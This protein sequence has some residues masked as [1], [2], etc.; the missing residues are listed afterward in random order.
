MLLD[1]QYRM[2]PSIA[3]FPSQMF[4]DGKLRSG[5]KASDRPAPQGPVWQLIHIESKCVNTEDI[6]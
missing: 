5:I 2:H 6:E 3:G 1:T 4:Y